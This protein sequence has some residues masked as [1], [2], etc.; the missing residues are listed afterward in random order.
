M[1]RKSAVVQPHTDTQCAGGPVPK[2]DED[3]C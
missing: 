2:E 3:T 1:N